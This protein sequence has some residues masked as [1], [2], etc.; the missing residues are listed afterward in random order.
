MH[1]AA[2][3]RRG[4][5]SP[6]AASTPA[7]APASGTS[8]PAPDSRI[9]TL[10]GMPAGGPAGAPSGTVATQAPASGAG[11]PVRAARVADLAFAVFLVAVA[12]YRYVV[13]TADG[14]PSTVDSGN[15]L[16]FGHTLLGDD[17]TRASSLVY[18]PVIPLA[19]AAL[20]SA[21]GPVTAVGVL[22]AVTSVAQAAG[23]YLALRSFGLRWAAGGMAGLLAVSSATGE[24]AAWG[25]FPQLL[26]AGL[27]PLL[28]LLTDRALR[29]APTPRQ[30]WGTTLGAAGC[31][32]GL[33]TTSHFV[34]TYAAFA[35][36]VLV[37]M[38]FA[39][40]PRGTRAGWLRVRATRLAVI[41]APA[42]LSLP[43]YVPLLTA[44]GGNRPT[45]TEA[46]ALT[47]ANL[48]SS[49]EF[50]YRDTPVLWRALVL[51]A[52]ATLVLLRD[53]WRE[54]LWR[55]AVAGLAAVVASTAV[56]LEA[57]SLFFLPLSAL[58]A[59]GLWAGSGAWPRPA[60]RYAVAGL[61]VAALAWQTTSGLRL[62][63]S[64]R[65]Y[66][67]IVTPGVYAAMD[68]LRDTPDGTRLGVTTVDD[69]PLGWWVEGYVQ[70][71][72]LYATPLRWLSY[73]DELDRARAA[74]EVFSPSFPDEHTLA[75]AWEADL[76]FLLIAV[77]SNRYEEARM[78]TF[79]ADRPCAVAYRNADAVILDVGGVQGCH[80]AS[81]NGT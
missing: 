70:R 53:R 73:G 64:Q 10:P 19:M 22:G 23:T 33:V 2:R 77:D 74:N 8:A 14:A 67:G 43:L 12:V 46:S 79:V 80:L 18:P 5:R 34:T 28:L 78:E 68:W 36:A 66:Y 16:A 45:S 55:L 71:P 1:D 30:H 40:Q 31:T 41:V 63:P 49:I 27:V 3:H 37:L 57:R 39:A 51:T 59:L 7:L 11:S 75:R 47:W 54:P 62:F 61:L 42:V 50:S 35:A 25:G 20:T 56:S 13:L 4:R 9:D 26:G 15:W 69:A 17:A 60:A 52:L 81:A 72:T 76:D 48:F 44:L 24:A 6:E 32:A 38:L 29:A 65:D 58:F 21:L